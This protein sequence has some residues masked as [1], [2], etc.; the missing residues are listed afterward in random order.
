MTRTRIRL[1]AVLAAG[2]LALA[3]APAAAQ[4]E[5]RPGDLHETTEGFCT[6]GFVFDGAGGTAGDD[7]YFATAAHCV[8]KVGDAVKDGDGEAFGTVAFVADD[9]PLDGD[10][11]HQDFAFIRVSPQHEPRVKAGVRGHTQYPA[12]FTIPDQTQSGDLIQFSGHGLGFDLL[13]PTR[14]DRFGL[15]LS[16]D[17]ERWGVAGPMNFGDSGGPLVHIESGKAL[18]IESRVCLRLCT[19]E[20]PTVQGMLTKATGA[21]FPVTLRTAGAG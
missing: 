17:A 15:L 4:T 20:G 11:A 10:D 1:A 5:L 16:D 12:G 8:D 6:L 7:T 21:G 19:D 2:A 9:E 3:A 13:Q 18:G 14:E